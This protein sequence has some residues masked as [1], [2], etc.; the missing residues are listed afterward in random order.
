MTLHL[1]VTHNH[2]TRTVPLIGSANDKSKMEDDKFGSNIIK[3]LNDCGLQFYPK[4]A[5]EM[6]RCKE[7]KKHNDVVHCMLTALYNEDN[8]TNNVNVKALNECISR[9]A[10]GYSRP[11]IP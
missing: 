9:L 2:Y 7:H 3:A 6:K 11:A 1:G 4:L 8:A 10:P 5:A